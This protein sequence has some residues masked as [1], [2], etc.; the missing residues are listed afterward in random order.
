MP[1]AE[2]QWARTWWGPHLLRVSDDVCGR[3][4]RGFVRGMAQRRGLLTLLSA[5][6][7]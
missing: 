3:R 1:E 2:V 5:P 7:P 6:Q 4:E